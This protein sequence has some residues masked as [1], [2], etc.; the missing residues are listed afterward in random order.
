VPDG[1]DV[2]L[3]V[4]GGEE[5]GRNIDVLAHRGR[6]VQVGTMG[7]GSA[8]LSLG[9]LMM[10]RA[11]IHGTVLR[12]RPLEEKIAVSRRFAAEVVPLFERGALRP[13]IDCRFPL[14]Q[15]A[16][17]HRHMEANANVGKILLDV[18]PA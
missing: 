11:S 3:D 17:A 5:L 9:A 18:H 7:G 6:I 1:F 13:V 10:K 16:D 2:V 14:A 8:Q 15:A 4:V 12:A